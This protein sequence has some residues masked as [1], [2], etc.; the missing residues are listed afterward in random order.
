MYSAKFEEYI[1]LER[2]MRI[3][4][5][6]HC[7]RTYNV[8]F[9]EYIALERTMWIFKGMHCTRTYNADF[10]RNAMIKMSNV[11]NAKMQPNAQMQTNADY[12]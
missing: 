5:G 7:T 4:K 9:Q 8:D 2:T 3:F 1:A 11:M 10:Q 6:M 12:F